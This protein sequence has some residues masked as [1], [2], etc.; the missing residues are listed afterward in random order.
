ME[1]LVTLRKIESLE[2]FLPMVDGII[3]GQ[4]FTTGYKMSKDDLRK[5]RAYCQTLNKK[6]YIVID[7]FITEDERMILLEYFSFIEELNPDGIYFHDLGIIDA[8]KSSN[9]A[10]RLIYD[11]KTVL[12][13]S[14]DAA[15]MLKNNIESV[16]ISR[17]LTLKEVSD[18]VTNLMGRVEMQIFGHLRMSYSRRR[19][20]TNYFR[21]INKDYDYLGKETLKLVEEQRDYA[22]PIVEDENGTYIYTDFIL[23]MFEEVVKLRPFLRRGIIDT[24]FIEDDNLIAQ[25]CRDYKRIDENNKQFVREAFLHNYPGNYSKGYLYQKT[26]ISK[27]G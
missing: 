11:G 17:E 7:N 24:L 13:N 5:A 27:D 22:M 20:L 3:T 4:S 16:V 1:L 26:N 15:F 12:C 9:M 6:F 2:K 10:N 18:I 14:L 19:F 25:V 21:E 8:A 23:E